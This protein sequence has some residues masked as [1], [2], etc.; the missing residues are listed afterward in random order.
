MALFLLRSSHDCTILSVLP[1][2]ASFH[3]A[4]SLANSA[5][6]MWRKGANKVIKFER[7]LADP[8]DLFHKLAAALEI[9]A[10]G[11]RRCVE[12]DKADWQ[13]LGG[14]AD[15]NPIWSLELCAPSTARSE[16]RSSFKRPEKLME[17]FASAFAKDLKWRVWLV[18]SKRTRVWFDE[19]GD[20]T[21]VSEEGFQRLWAVHEL[22]PKEVRAQF[23]NG[24]R[25][26]SQADRSIYG[27]LSIDGHLRE[28][29]D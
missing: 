19:K 27:S 1:K 3:S 5:T 4:T 13:R 29:I 26:V 24:G 11:I 6:K 28:I 7:E 21:G 12:A 8:P 18:L 23:A 20:R 14:R 10:D 9:S 16:S 2:P 15:S 25:R 17:Q 22:G